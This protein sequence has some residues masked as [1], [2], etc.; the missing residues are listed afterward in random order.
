MIGGGVDEA[1][2]AYKDINEVMKYQKNKLVDV[3]GTFTPKVVRMAD[4]DGGFKKKYKKN[5]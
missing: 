2:Y 3:L 5:K 4:D 1:P